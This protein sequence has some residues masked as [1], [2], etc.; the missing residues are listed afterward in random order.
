MQKAGE[1]THQ[2]SLPCFEQE[3]VSVPGRTIKN[4]HLHFLQKSDV[5]QGFSLQVLKDHLIS[6]F[7]HHLSHPIQLSFHFISLVPC[8]KVKKGKETC[9]PF[10]F[11]STET[12]SQL[13]NLSS[14]A[15]YLSPLHLDLVPAAFEQ[16]EQQH[17][18]M[19]F[20]TTR[21]IWALYSTGLLQNLLYVQFNANWKDAH[22]HGFTLSWF[23]CTVNKPARANRQ[24]HD[25][26]WAILGIAK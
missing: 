26:F 18:T 11:V 12:A 19:Q 20:S 1:P 22:V 17:S 9:Q 21:L 5:T 8:Q 15:V 6:F 13:L 24:S 7:L 25:S 3:M 14:Q 16:F 23:L 4:T 2:L 10:S